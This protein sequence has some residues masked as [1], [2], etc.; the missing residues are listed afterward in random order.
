MYKGVIN[1]PIEVKAH[2]PIP[3]E[4]LLNDGINTDIKEVGKPMLISLHDYTVAVNVVLTGVARG[5]TASIKIMSCG[6]EIPHAVASTTSMASSFVITMNVIEL[7]HAR[8]A[9]TECACLSVV[10]D[11]D[12]TINAGSF[13][14]A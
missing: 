12:C 7:M 4:T 13:C 11:T 9:D 14:V 3:F 5:T 1:N 6:E 2:E 8:K 10:C